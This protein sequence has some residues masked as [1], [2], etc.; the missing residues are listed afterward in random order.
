MGFGEVLT[1]L[2]VGNRVYD[3]VVRRNA[4][5]YRVEYV[6]N[7][8]AQ[9]NSAINVLLNLPS[10]PADELPSCTEELLES[11]ALVVQAYQGP[12][13]S[14][15][16]NYM[17]AEKPTLEL[18]EKAKFCDKHRRPETLHGFLR[19][20]QWSNPADDL[21]TDVVL[22]LEKPENGAA[23][24]V[25]APRAYMTSKEQV[26]SDTLHWDVFETCEQQKIRD[27]IRDFFQAHKQ[28]LRCFVSFP[29]ELP[30]PEGRTLT[31]LP[32]AV[33][34]VQ[35]DKEAAFGKFSKNQRKLLLLMAPFMQI[36][37][38]GIAWVHSE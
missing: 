2:E 6:E 34:N 21:P 24:L 4:P 20:V 25:G 13:V 33:V 30:T 17:V 38:H 23:C 19:L 5:L 1:G 32:R 8:V 3:A 16:S 29:I 9:M 14:L 27:E 15:L 37:A 7:Y 18:V 12:E 28:K 36:M 26:V 31:V 35:C 11:A 10:M 22:P